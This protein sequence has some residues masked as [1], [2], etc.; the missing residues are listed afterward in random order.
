MRPLF[1]F[2]LWCL[3]WAA[4]GACSG[5]GLRVMDPNASC[6]CDLG[7]VGAQCQV[8]WS[9]QEGTRQRPL[10]AGVC[11]VVDGFGILNPSSGIATA[12]ASL[13]KV[14][15]TAGYPVTVAYTNALVADPVFAE[16][17]RFYRADSG[18]LLVR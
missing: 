10:A 12:Y 17:A 7:F 8:P 3:Y 15:R 5:R 14:L 11:L 1:V 2:S 16:A 4:D 18:V 6:L 9:A 13:A